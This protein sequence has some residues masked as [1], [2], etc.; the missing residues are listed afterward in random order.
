M[1]TIEERIKVEQ[2]IKEEQKRK[3]K[4]L[5]AF[6]TKAYKKRKLIFQN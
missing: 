6:L 2:K 4:Y 1:Q 3:T 5:K